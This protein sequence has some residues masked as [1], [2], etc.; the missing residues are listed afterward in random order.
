MQKKILLI[1]SSFFI[2]I[3]II[4]IYLFID[5]VYAMR[6]FE[7]SEPK[8]VDAIVCLVGGTGRIDEALRLMAQ[9]KARILILSGVNKNVSLRDILKKSN[10]KEQILEE[11]IKIENLSKNTLENTLHTAQYLK[12][13]NYQSIILIT[14]LYHIK[15][16]SF[17]F[18]KILPE[19]IKIY[20]HPIVTFENKNWWNSS[21]H[22]RLM[23]YE[24]IKYWWYRITL[25]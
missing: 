6:S 20:I 18:K 1:I 24:F 2:A 10:Y 19:Q 5:F 13:N 7:I 9:R 12:T 14:S 17:M 15:R 16:A 3:I 8:E 21:Y 11:N 23:V 22:V 25:I 4:L